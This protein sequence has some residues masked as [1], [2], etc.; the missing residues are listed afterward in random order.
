MR[1]LVFSGDVWH[2][3]HIVRA[4]LERLED[5]GF[6]FDWIDHADERSVEQMFEYP[7]VM[8]TKANQVSET[9]QRPWVTDKIEK[10]FSDYVHQGGGLLV[11]H[12]GLAGYGQAPALRRLMGG[13]FVEH[14]DPCPV[15]VDLKDGHPLTIGSLPFTLIDEHY[16]VAVDDVQAD[17]FMT[18]LSEHGT[19]PGGWTR[20][21]GAGRVCVMTPSHSREGWVHPSFQTLLLNALRWCGRSES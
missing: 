16:F 6:Q 4:G 8:L 14:P 12:S 3:T 18:T 7:L 17:V 13:R 2:P 10:D 20:T 9:D 19:Q 15:T 5:S 1:A 21:E 11:V